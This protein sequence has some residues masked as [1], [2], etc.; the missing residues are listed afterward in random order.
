MPKTQSRSSLGVIGTIAELVLVAAIAAT[1]VPILWMV[2]LSFQPL[3]NIIGADINLGFSLS[4]YTDLLAPGNPLLAQLGN[5]LMI[6]VGTVL[7]CLVFGSLAGYALSQLVIPRMVLLPLLALTAFIP[8]IPPMV[9]VPGLYATMSSFGLIGGTLGLVILNTVFQL[10]FAALLMKVYFDGLPPALREAA[11]IDGASEATAFRSVM[12]PLV[13]PG[14]ASVATFTGIM[15]W[16]EFL[17]GLT[18]TSGGVTAP[19]TVGIASLVQPFEVAWGQM[20]A[21]GTLAAIPII[22]I[23][24]IANRYIVAGLT[25]GA[26]KG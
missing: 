16:N 22:I 4:N 19:L 1:I 18:M 5:S 10:P 25:A 20:A 3:K 13:K 17:F 15:A 23:T 12:L 2:A 21:A 8:L 9:L 6:V 26:V 14:L 7:L 24:I 11:L